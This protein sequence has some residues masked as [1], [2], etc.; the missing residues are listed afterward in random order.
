MCE[1][2]EGEKTIDPGGPGEA[3]TAKK[4]AYCFDYDS[5]EAYASNGDCRLAEFKFFSIH[6]MSRLRI[7]DVLTKISR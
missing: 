3:Q 2:C 6:C 7:S 4:E 1:P 5:G